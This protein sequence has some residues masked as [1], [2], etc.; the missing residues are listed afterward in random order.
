MPLENQDQADVA[1]PDQDL[2]LLR[3]RL[4]DAATRLCRGPLTLH[5]EDIVQ[6]ALLR[7]REA[8]LRGDVERSVPASYLSRAAFSALVDEVRRQ[9]RRREVP[10]EEV[11][12]VPLPRH[13][14]GD[15]ERAGGDAD[16]RRAI[17]ACLATLVPPRRL[18]VTLHLQGHSGREAARLLAWAEKRVNNLIYRGLGDLRRC[19]ASKGFA[20]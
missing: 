16:I 12:D 14:P 20:P 3:R 9:R 10:V 8:L 17:R 15:P 2:I 18:A 5:L 4:H 11:R 6:T 1:I 7:V 13:H 19:L